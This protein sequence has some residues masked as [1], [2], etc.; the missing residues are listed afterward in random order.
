MVLDD[1][2]EFERVVPTRHEK[3]QTFVALRPWISVTFLLT[4]FSATAF[5]YCML[6]Y[7]ILKG[8]VK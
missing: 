6:V 7:E 1:K 4:A 8:G 3:V 2:D 5:C